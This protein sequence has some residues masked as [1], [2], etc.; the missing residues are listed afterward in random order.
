MPPEL[1]KPITSMN[2]MTCENCVF[3]VVERHTD[4]LVAMCYHTTPVLSFL[5]TDS[6]EFCSEG[7]WLWVGV[8]SSIADD[9]PTLHLFRYD[10]L[11]EMFA[12]EM[13]YA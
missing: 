10:E 4:S 9:K 7:Q 11:Y 3:S 1:K 12:R 5:R 2:E 8:W 13:S 6:V